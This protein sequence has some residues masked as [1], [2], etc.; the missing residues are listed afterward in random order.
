MPHGIPPE[1]LATQ[2]RE[3]IEG[4]SL[5]VVIASLPRDYRSRLVMLLH[6]VVDQINAQGEYLSHLENELI[7]SGDMVATAFSP[8]T[9][10]QPSYVG[11]M[12]QSAINANKRMVNLLEFSQG[13]D[14]F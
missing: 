14:I 3:A 10:P 9:A 4:L 6:D 12:A 11:S 13:E 5:R 8:N 2:Q 7:K 1:E